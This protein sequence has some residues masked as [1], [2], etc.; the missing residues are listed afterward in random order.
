[1]AHY[2]SFRINIVIA[3]KHIITDRIIDGSNVFHNTNV[4]II[5]IFCVGPPPYY[6]DW[7]E[8][9]YPNVPLNQ[10]V[11]LFFIQCI[12][13]VQGTRPSGRQCN[14]LLDEV[15]TIIKYKK[16]TIDNDIYIKV[17]SDVTVYYIAV[18]TDDVLNTT[19]NDTEFTELTR[20]FEEHFEM[21]FQ[22]GPVL[23]YLNLRI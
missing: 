21:I 19:N 8:R 17:L 18:S 1:M 23:K 20:V 22:E 14:R 11:G 4:T 6:I 3:A 7:F 9:Y 16:R 12:N 2:D 15:V 5:E 13:R 10:D